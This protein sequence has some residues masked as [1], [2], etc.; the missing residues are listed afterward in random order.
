MRDIGGDKFTIKEDIVIIEFVNISLD[1]PK[2]ESKF[3]W[4]C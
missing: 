2:L 3:L 1:E 4:I